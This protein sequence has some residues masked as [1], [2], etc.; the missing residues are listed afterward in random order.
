[1]TTSQS[2]Q[3]GAAERDGNF[4]AKK[5]EGLSFLLF[6][7]FTH[8]T[9]ILGE[10]LSTD[11]KLLIGQETRC[12]TLRPLLLDLFSEGGQDEC[13]RT[14]EPDTILMIGGLGFLLVTGLMFVDDFKSTDGPINVRL[15][16]SLND[17]LGE[18]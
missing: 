4:R 1:M 5:K 12:V 6:D 11:F 3:P 2:I 9:P 10:F 13:V 14:I 7:E 18:G 17:L 8:L 15:D 16:F